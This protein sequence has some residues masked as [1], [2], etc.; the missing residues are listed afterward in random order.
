MA[1]KN[2]SVAAKFAEVTKEKEDKKIKE[3]Q[4]KPEQK[5]AATKAATPKKKPEGK[6][7]TLT[8]EDRRKMK[9]DFD[10]PRVDPGQTELF[11][12][13]QEPKRKPGQPRKYDE[14]VKR[15]S[16]A[17]PESSIEKLELLSAIHG[18]NKTQFILGVIETAASA[19]AE[20]IENYKKLIGKRGA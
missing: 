18:I 8:A 16:F 12:Q 10:P 9:T 2:M 11:S 13:E 1:K 6:K 15:I 17:L 19:S 5:P 3:K 20:K 14:P 4:P 7:S